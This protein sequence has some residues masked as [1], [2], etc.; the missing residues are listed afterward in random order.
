MS[1]PLLDVAV[2][3]SGRGSN[4]AALVAATRAGTCRARIVGLISD[5]PDAGAL[6]IA[7]EAGIETTVVERSSFR[8]RALWNE[9]VRDAIQEL[10]PSLV[11]LAG[12]MR[13]IGPAILAAFPDR[14]I[15]IHPSLLPAFPGLHAPQQAIDAGV[16]VTGCTVHRVDEGVDTGAIL[17]QGAV[18]V[19]PT[20]DA[21]M[22]HA[23]L[24]RIEHHL[25]PAVVNMLGGGDTN[26]ANPE[27]DLI[28]L[29]PSPLPT[30][31][32]ESER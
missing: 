29:L 16:R 13:I 6:A 27:A 7:E 14:I 20:D 10:R 4:F 12:F 22:L 8:T 25:L 26:P 17:A 23:R 21:D 18:V 32:L 9:G 2:L 30:V 5:N 15:N 19:L 1:A 24:Q 11:V 28:S 31:S 3:A